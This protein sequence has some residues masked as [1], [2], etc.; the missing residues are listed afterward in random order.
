LGENGPQGDAIDL[1]RQVDD[2]T[3]VRRTIVRSVHDQVSE[4]QKAACFVMK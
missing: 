4:A 2:E 3:S 1:A